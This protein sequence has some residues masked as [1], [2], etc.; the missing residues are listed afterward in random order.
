MKL[1]SFLSII[2]LSC[3]LCNNIFAQTTIIDYER[4]ANI[5]Y[6]LRNIKDPA[7]RAMVTEVLS[8]P[9]Y[10]QLINAKEYSVYRK[11]NSD[12]FSSAEG[13]SYESVSKQT[14]KDFT[15][16]LYYKES[17]LNG[18]NYIIKDTI[19]SYNWKF[20]DET[21]M[22]AG[23]NCKKAIAESDTEE[24]TAWITKDIV[25]N[26]GPDI[27]SVNDGTILGLE[28]KEESYLATKVSV[29]D[30][31]ISLSKPDKGEIISQEEYDKKLSEFMSRFIMKD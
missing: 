23:Y 1:K 16:S 24:I 22:I 20:K 13:V 31:S 21:K 12:E 17:T 28:F 30:K 14:Y 7:R 9:T 25:L 8:Q 3:L 5:E 2:F 6:Q 4:R 11:T 15:T 26:D 10:F 27:Y 18:K 19:E 29:S